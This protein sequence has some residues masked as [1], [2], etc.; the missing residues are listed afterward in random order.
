MIEQIKEMYPEDDFLVADGYNEAI[1]GLDESS[2]RLIYSV[3]RVI[4]ILEQDMSRE[5]ALDHF[6][7]NMHGSYVGEKTPIWCMDMVY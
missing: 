7:F 3:S 6:Y 1:I 5:D 2:G 4:E